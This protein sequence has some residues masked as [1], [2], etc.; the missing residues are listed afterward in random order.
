MITDRVRCHRCGEQVEITQ[1]Q[2]PGFNKVEVRPCACLCKGAGTLSDRKRAEQH[3]A[4]MAYLRGLY[5]AHVVP[6]GAD[7]PLPPKLDRFGYPVEE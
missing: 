5:G 1:Y 3:N 6:A 7:K 4:H 2:H